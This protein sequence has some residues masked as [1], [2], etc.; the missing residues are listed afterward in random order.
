MA[1]RRKHPCP[2]PYRTDG[3]MKDGVV[4]RIITRYGSAP[5]EADSSRKTAKT[6]K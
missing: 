6:L 2:S 5:E 1:L 4:L 3:C